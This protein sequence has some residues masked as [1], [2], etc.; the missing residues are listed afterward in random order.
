MWILVIVDIIKLTIEIPT[1]YCTQFLL[2]CLDGV[3]LIIRVIFV[4][5]DKGRAKKTKTSRKT[6]FVVQ[7][8]LG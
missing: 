3:L 1:V 7:I 8:R 5:V 6:Y 2:I 4:K